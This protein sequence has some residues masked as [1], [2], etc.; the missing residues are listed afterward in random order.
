MD[1]TARLMIEIDPELDRRLR[2]KAQKDNRKLRAV[3]EIALTEYLDREDQ[4]EEE[5]SKAEAIS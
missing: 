2:E 4:A 3:V 1:R 5:R